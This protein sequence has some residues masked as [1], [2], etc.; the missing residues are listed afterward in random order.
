M[1]KRNYNKTE[2]LQFKEKMEPG[3]LWICNKPNW[4]LYNYSTGMRGYSPQKNTEPRHIKYTHKSVI[5][6]YQR[7]EA[8]TPNHALF[9]AGF[10]AGIYEFTYRLETIR[11]RDEFIY[12]FVKE[13]T[14]V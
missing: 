12:K 6:A 7:E 14:R 2:R 3:G 1:S 10:C 8:L 5:S 9:M 11:M 4:Y 13:W